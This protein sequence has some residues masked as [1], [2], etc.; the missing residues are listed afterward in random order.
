MTDVRDGVGDSG[1]AMFARYAYPPNERGYCGPGEPHTLLEA[2]VSGG[3]ERLLSHLARQFEGAWPYLELIA[4]CNAINDPL[5]RRVVEAYWIGN[6]LT[7]RVPASLLAASLDERFARRAGARFAP[8]VAAAWNG[9][10]AQHSFHVFAVY[11]WLGMLRAGRVDAPFDVVDRCRIR[12]GRVLALS[13]DLV[14][15][16]C[17]RLELV[18][19]QLVLGDERVESARYAQ[20]GL[21]FVGDLAVG[22]TV[23]LHWDWVC[24]RLTLGALERLARSTRDNL[25]AVNSLVTC[26]SAEA[27]EHA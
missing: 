12:W 14:T 8:L 17:R 10:V 7:R 11:P 15:V 1:P 23:A 27:F 24:E 25:S 3:E 4:G 21:A 22:D 2:A 9:G 19:G 16:T 20:S 5:D 13:G 26:P 6:S 18:A